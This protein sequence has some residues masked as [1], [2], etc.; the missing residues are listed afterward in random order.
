[1]VTNLILN[2]GPIFTAESEYMF[3]LGYFIFAV[4]AYMRWAIVVINSF[5]DFLGIHCLTIPNQK[6]K[7]A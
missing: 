4:V 3:L 6:K 2:S 7:E 1:M 5:C